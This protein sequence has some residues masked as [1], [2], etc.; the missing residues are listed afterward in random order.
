MAEEA[1]KLA[2]NWEEAAA[3]AP[4]EARATLTRCVGCATAAAAV[5][6]SSPPR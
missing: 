4:F 2:F 3:V 5:T 1:G 6:S